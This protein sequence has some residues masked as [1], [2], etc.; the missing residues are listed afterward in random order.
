MSKYLTRERTPTWFLNGTFCDSPSRSFTHKM[1]R[2]LVNPCPLRRLDEY[3]EEEEV[4]KRTIRPILGGTMYNLFARFHSWESLWQMP[5]TVPSGEEQGSPVLAPAETTTP[6]CTVAVSSGATILSWMGITNDL[7]IE[8]YS[9]SSARLSMR[10][11]VT[12]WR[13]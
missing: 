13:V 6:Q 7:T 8:P 11:A 2:D 4:L 3:A 12:A 5:E 10:C 1:R 9:M